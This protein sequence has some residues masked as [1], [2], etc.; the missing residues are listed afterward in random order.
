MNALDQDGL[1]ALDY[2]QSW[3]ASKR[4]LYDLIQEHRRSRLHDLF[5]GQFG[6]LATFSDPRSG[7]GVAFHAGLLMQQAQLHSEFCILN[8]LLLESL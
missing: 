5:G 3:V 4:I 7:P 6:K 8:Y 2:T 1:T